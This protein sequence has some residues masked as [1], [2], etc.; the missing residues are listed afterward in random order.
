MCLQLASWV[1]QAGI[2]LLLCSAPSHVTRGMVL[3]WQL[4][5]SAAA[6]ACVVRSASAAQMSHGTPC[7]GAVALRSVPAASAAHH[8]ASFSVKNLIPVW[9]LKPGPRSCAYAAWILLLSPVA[10][11]VL[12][13]SLTATLRATRWSTAMRCWPRSAA[14][15]HQMRDAMSR[16]TSA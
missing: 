3:H 16:P 7:G 9:L 6:R 5:S 1:A 8:H 13:R 12:R 11:L 15:L 10:V 14:P 2:C 4:H